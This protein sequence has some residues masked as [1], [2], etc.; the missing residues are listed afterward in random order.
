MTKIKI[1]T[2]ST[3]GL[4]PE[5]VAKY[6]IHILPLTVEIDGKN[7]DATELEPT[8]FM[9]KMAAAKQLPKSSQ[10][11]IGN[12][13]ALFEE[14]TADGSEVLAIHLTEKLSGTVLTAQ[15][16]ADMVPGKVTVI[17]SDYIARALAFQVIEAAKMAQ[18]ESNTVEDILT[19]ISSIRAKTKLYICV[20]TLE[21]LIKGGRVG[22]MQGIIG[23]LL[24]IK[25]I[26]RLQDGALVEEAK[27][28][29]KKKTM[30]YLV[31]ILKAETKKVKE[32]NIQ[33]ANG[34]QM[35]EEIKTHAKEIFHLSNVLVLNADSVISTHAGN[36]AF[37]M[38]YYTE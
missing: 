38:I 23:S 7:Y 37:A 15:Q 36:G 10:P 27:I 32:L 16:A 34:L 21:N 1:V 17:D 11:A 18:K 22:R 30:D 20:V 2:D 12:I 14:L 6:N 13:V 5:E 29:S 28:R 24:N 9:A 8:D 31:D 3:A 35:A 4:T 26:A 25:L 33:H 19:K